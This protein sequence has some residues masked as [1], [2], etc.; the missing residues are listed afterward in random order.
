MSVRATPTILPLVL[1]GVCF[2]TAGG[3]SLL[4]PIDLRLDGGERTIILGYN[5]AGK[6]LL[7][8]LCHGLIAP[9]RG[10][11]SWTGPGATLR[12][13]A[14]RRHAM[15]FQRP[16]MLRRSVED[17]VRHALA[18]ANL[19]GPVCRERA[20]DALER[21]DLSP[22]AGRAARV[23][24]GGEQQRLAMARAWAL[25][26][27]VLFLD[28][29]TASLDPATT[30]AVESMILGFSAEGIGVVMTTHDPHQA[31][32]LAQRVIFLHRGLIVEDG[33]ADAFFAQ[34]RSAEAAAWLKGE[35]ID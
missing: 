24:S 21:F 1:R 25:R 14:G 18:A 4:G 34:P 13:E 29:P 10:E 26:P 12:T 9:S 33:P 30:R 22:L 19:S 11:V 32:R 7:L 17:N 8:R 20:R 27:E 3:R 35:L 5:G 6:S 28:E 31:R 16:V 2:E 15:V 23:L